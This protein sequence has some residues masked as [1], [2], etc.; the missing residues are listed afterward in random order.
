MS[1]SAAIGEV[2]KLVPLTEERFRGSPALGA[3]ASSAVELL[4]AVL[5]SLDQAGLKIQQN[6]VQDPLVNQ[7]RVLTGQI[8]NASHEHRTV[9]EIWQTV[10]TVVQLLF[11]H[12]QY[13]GVRAGTFADAFA[14]MGMFVSQLYSM[15]E[16]LAQASALMEV[17]KQKVVHGSIV[18]HYHTEAKAYGVRKLVAGGVACTFAV[19]FLTTLVI[20]MCTIHSY[21]IDNGLKDFSNLIVA[22]HLLPRVTFTAAL[23]F[24]ALVGFRMFMVYSHREAHLRS[25]EIAGALIPIV[26]NELEAKEQKELYRE[27]L[28]KAMEEEVRGYLGNEKT[29]VSVGSAKLE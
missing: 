19:G 28:K 13:S 22:I 8:S 10:A 7:I 14:G 24:T 27:F 18:E 16:R 6:Q 5:E 17:F 29:T 21:V 23:L 25:R 9:T 15:L 3:Q 1:L 11:S 20:S 12:A 26:A 4:V 2:K